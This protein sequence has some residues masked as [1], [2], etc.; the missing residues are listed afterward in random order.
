LQPNH[1]GQPPHA[2]GQRPHVAALRP[3]GCAIH[4]VRGTRG[5][6]PGKPLG[7]ARPAL[8]PPCILHRPF[9]I[10]PQVNPRAGYARRQV[11]VAA[12]ADAG[13]GRCAV[14]LGLVVWGVFRM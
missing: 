9:A 13:Q 2:R 14:G 7:R 5:G 6:E 1:G 10:A 11:R 4:P 3:L 12:T 8:L